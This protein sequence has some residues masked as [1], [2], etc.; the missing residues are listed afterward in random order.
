MRR[1]LT[2]APLRE[3]SRVVANAHVLKMR[4][5][6]GRG[7][8]VLMTQGIASGGLTIAYY[9]NEEASVVKARSDPYA[10]RMEL[11]RSRKRMTRDRKRRA[12]TG[13]RQG[14][15]KQKWVI[16]TYRPGHKDTKCCLPL[17]TGKN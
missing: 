1:V 8:N 13:S 6:F 4:L 10:F 17:R 15:R 5:L 11:T 14:E 12:L 16:R 3:E 9:A 2:H 7:E